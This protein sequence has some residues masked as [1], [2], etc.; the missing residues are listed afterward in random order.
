MTKPKNKDVRPREYLTEKE[1]KLLVKVA[2][3]HPTNGHRDSAMIL[4]AFLH[5]LRAKELINLKW[6]Q[7]NFDEGMMDVKRVKNGVNCTHPITS[8]ET[9]ALK[10]IKTKSSYVFLSR[11]KEPI[12]TRTFYDVV[13]KA[14][15][16]AGF[17]FPIHPHMLRHA[18]GRKLA[19]DGH[20]L[21]KI[22]LYMG[23]KNVNNTIIYMT[24]QGKQY[25]GWMED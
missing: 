9:R 19:T 5:G 4:V 16:N 15:K 1:V 6:S 2:K 3:K 8:R 7:F 12:A 10:K 18:T 25:E 21:N 20:D 17:N 23:H 24:Y 22:R 13:Q 14:G 11:F